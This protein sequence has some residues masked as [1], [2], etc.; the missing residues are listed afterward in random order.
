MMGNFSFGDYFKD[1]AVDYAWEC[2]TRSR[3]LDPSGSG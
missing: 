1:E 3:S 2:V